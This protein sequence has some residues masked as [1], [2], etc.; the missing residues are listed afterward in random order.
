ME[1]TYIY[2]FHLQYKN[3]LANSKNQ[4]IYK[5]QE[6]FPDQWSMQLVRLAMEKDYNNKKESFKMYYY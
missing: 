2:T 6:T 1:R 4:V 3:Q 5:L